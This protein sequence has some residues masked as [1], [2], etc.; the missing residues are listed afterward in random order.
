MT[1]VFDARGDSEV[2]PHVVRRIGLTARAV[3]DDGLEGT[4]R[5]RDDLRAPG[6]TIPLIGPVGSFCDTI[7][8]VLAAIGAYPTPVATA[9]LSIVVDPRVSP[10]VI[11]TQPSIVRKGRTSVVTEMVLAAG[12]G[13]TCGYC[14]MSS[15][16]LT[17]REPQAVDP[18]IVTQFLVEG[19]EP[20]RPHFYDEI[21]IT[22]EGDGRVS[23]ALQPFLGNSMGMMHG[24]V[25]VMLA[26]AAAVSTARSR[27]GGGGALATLEAQV[28]Y[29]N[30][31]RVGPVV[32]T[33]SVV[34]AS[35]RSTTVRVEQR[36]VG[37]DRL[38]SVAFA[39]VESVRDLRRD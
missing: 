32:A 15:T 29:L 31:A 3:G 4:L 27:L 16:V 1:Q 5:L 39:R 11:T 22:D 18:R 25:T 10:D 28:R 30:G 36:D 6:T 20:H 23:L 13:A 14:V 35:D 21:G 8:G 9:D 37:A 38:T 19:H 7:G 17:D 33:G 24:G 2:E 26:D 34:A 12:D